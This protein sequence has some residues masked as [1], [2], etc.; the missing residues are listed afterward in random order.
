M[1]V[2]NERRRHGAY[3]VSESG[4]AT[5][6]MRSREV[7]T[8][9]LGNVLDDGTVLGQLANKE[10]TAFDPDAVDGSQTPVA[11][12]FG[13][14]DTSV[15]AKSVVVNVRECEVNGHELTWPAAISAGA[16]ATA[17]AA[18][19]TKGIVVR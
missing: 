16:K 2:F 13:S 10:Y 9:A 14:V 5:G 11:V 4:G 18:L 19:A 7:G 6:G 3:L 1:T 15:A 8:L 17:I 12:L